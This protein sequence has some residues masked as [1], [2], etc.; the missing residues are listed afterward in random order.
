M[1]DHLK[2]ETGTTDSQAVENLDSEGKKTSQS[3][4][5]RKRKPPPP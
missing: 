2:M 3:F 5:Q 1:P 4:P